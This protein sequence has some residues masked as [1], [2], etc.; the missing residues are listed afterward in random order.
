MFQGSPSQ[1]A[2]HEPVRYVAMSGY[3]MGEV[4]TTR[5]R[6]LVGL[7]SARWPAGVVAGLAALTAG[8]AVPA[9][10]SRLE[11]VDRLLVAGY[12]GV[13]A[14]AGGRAR[15]WT[16]LLLAVIAATFAGVAW[17]WVAAGGAVV[18]T[19]L[20]V[21]RRRS[22]PLAG[23]VVGGLGALGT[24][25]LVDGGV[26][27]TSLVLGCAAV[28]P[29]VWSGYRQA[30]HAPRRAWRLTLA[31]STFAVFAIGLI[32]GVA[33]LSAR[34]AADRGVHGLQVAL[35]AGRAGDLDGASTE[36]SR[37]QRDLDQASRHLGAWWSSPARAVPVLGQNAE[38]ASAAVDVARGL[39]AAA[40]EVV[41][42]AGSETLGMHDGRFDPAAFE[43]LRGPLEG[44]RAAVDRAAGRVD[45]LDSPWLLGKVTMRLDE[46][47][48]EVRR[49][50]DDVGVGLQGVDATPILLGRGG[51]R[52]YLVL[53]VT[54][55]EARATGF[56][57][58]YA[59]LVVSDGRFSLP[60]FGR[61]SE[62]QVPSQPQPP[63]DL[64]QEFLDR[65]LRFGIDR[66]IQSVTTSPDFPSVARLASQLYV[67]AGNQRVDG[68]LSVDPVALAAL[69]GLTG[70]I[71][72]PGLDRPL[73][74]ETAAT[75]LLRDQYLDLPD[76]SVRVDALEGI[77]QT[78]FSR[79]TQGTL[80]PPQQLIGA[81]GPAVVAGNL[82]FAVFD[83]KPASFLARI[84]IDHPLPRPAADSI[85]VTTTNVVGGKLDLFLQRT[86]DYDSTWDPSTGAVTATLRVTMRNDSP[87]SGLP[88]YVIRDAIPDEDL[89]PGTN[90]SR[91]AIYSPWQLDGATIDGR[92]LAVEVTRERGHHVYGSSVEL[93]PN[94]GSATIE[95]R[96]SGMLTPN[97]DYELA[98]WNQVMARPDQLRAA[99]RV[100]GQRRF[101]VEGLRKEGRRATVDERPGA[102]RRYR[103]HAPGAPT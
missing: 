19:G 77:S 6:R 33:V 12:V 42:A 56:V 101:E 69:V 50:G 20:S 59:E 64:P 40:S 44:L 85:A 22:L 92:P 72:V 61:V 35:A 49:A 32:Y 21:W 52:T 47:R 95:L 37:A 74:S 89:P 103:I 94:G 62:L 91:V 93:A 16:W 3:E 63:L 7:L 100:L 17:A 90:R 1:R 78:A 27:G 88:D 14:L 46:A 70:P 86:L 28:G 30:P 81:L 73:T 11:V 53:F 39:T 2:G 9:H 60:R 8:L 51:R 4:T 18:L 13:V 102:P 75:F 38:A 57:G 87:S 54:P 71:S 55:V 65:Y 96:L 31:G 5:S 26:T 80:P 15:R 24:L 23:S 83:D 66:T 68:V 41:S 84:G 43:S 58:N 98:V 36:L 10:P 48:A 97:Q 79:L 67:Q 76:T 29:L 25:R 82:R 45:G 99:V 34:S